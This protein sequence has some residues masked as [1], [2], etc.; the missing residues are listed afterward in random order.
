MA[1]RASTTH[2]LPRLA[3]RPRQRDRRAEDRADRGRARAIE[4]RPLARCAAVDRSAPRAD[5][6]RERRPERHRRR[7]QPAAYSRRGVANHGHGL[8][9]RPGVICPSATASRN[10][11]AVIQW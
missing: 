11:A 9:H 10:W 8:Y 6:E 2:V 5:D 1:A 3:Q 7:Q 4:E